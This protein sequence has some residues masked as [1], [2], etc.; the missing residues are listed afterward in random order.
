MKEVQILVLENCEPI[1]TSHF[2][3]LII[4]TVVRMR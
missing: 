2:E 1:Q 4:M 3:A